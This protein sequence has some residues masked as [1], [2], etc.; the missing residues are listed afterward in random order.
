MQSISEFFDIAKI[1]YLRRKN[2]DASI[3]QGVRH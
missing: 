2:A 3:T 1:G